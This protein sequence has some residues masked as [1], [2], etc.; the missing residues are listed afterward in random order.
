MSGVQYQG[1]YSCR[2]SERARQ[3]AVPKCRYDSTA[4]ACLPSGRSLAGDTGFVAEL[5]EHKLLLFHQDFNMIVQRGAGRPCLLSCPARGAKQHA[6]THPAW[7]QSRVAAVRPMAYKEGED[8]TS[9][10]TRD[11]V[12]R[13]MH[14]QC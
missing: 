10:E 3:T 12:S 5:L 6:V 11:K 2:L 13:M 9:D 4:C 14:A 1:A 8:K 7:R